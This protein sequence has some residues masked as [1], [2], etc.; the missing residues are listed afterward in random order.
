M[1]LELGDPK[2]RLA[3]GQFAEFGV[4]FLLGQPQKF[5]LGARRRRFLAFFVLRGAS[6]LLKGDTGA[7][8]E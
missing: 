4:A 2:S 1:P 7:R 8:V 5:R 6:V 3:L